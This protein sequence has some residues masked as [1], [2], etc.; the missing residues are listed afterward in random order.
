MK[1][2]LVVDD[3]PLIRRQVAETLLFYGFEQI[4]E[5]ENGKQ[6]VEL[7]CS[8]RPLLIMMDVSMPVMDG[9]TAAEKIG[10]QAPAPIVLLTGNRDM[11]TIERARL[12]G[13]MSYLVKPFRGEEAYPAIDLA[14]H[15]FMQF[16]TLRDE[17]AHLRETLENRKIID[18]AKAALIKKGLSEPEAYRKMQ[19]IAMDK[20]KSLKEVAD[21]ILLME[22]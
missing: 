7:A 20:R 2:A 3:E 10:K 17:V 16:T 5:A 21:A 9:I 18:K 4:L 12:A 14:I 22:G 1:L 8:R 19:K 6:A 13:V 11:E 15:H